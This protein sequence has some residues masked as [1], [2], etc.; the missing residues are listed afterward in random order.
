MSIQTTVSW[1]KAQVLMDTKRHIISKHVPYRVVRCNRRHWQG[2]CKFNI[3]Y[4]CWN[5][6]FSP[7]VKGSGALS[8]ILQPSLSHTDLVPL[9]APAPSENIIWSL[10]SAFCLLRC[11]WKPRRRCTAFSWS[12]NLTVSFLSQFQARLIHVFGFH[13]KKHLFISVCCDQ[14]EW[15][16]LVFLV[17][18]LIRICQRL[19]VCCW[20]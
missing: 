19:F 2:S 12:T 6:L 15:V 7:T 13:E 17:T 16:L 4:V 9:Q 18:L 3:S 14:A 8:C 5:S 10:L 11:A 20:W 1:F